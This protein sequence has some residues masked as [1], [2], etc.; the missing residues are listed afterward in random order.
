M[1]DAPGPSGPGGG[2]RPG[3]SWFHQHWKEVL[4]LMVA[5][6]PVAAYFLLRRQSNSNAAPTAFLGGGAAGGSSGGSGT[7]S[8]PASGPAT[9]WQNVTASI[10][11]FA[12]QGIVADWDRTVG[13][14]AGGIP[15]RP[16][17][18][19]TISAPLGYA[20]YGSSI[21]ITGPAIKAASNFGQ[22]A[23]GGSE[24]WYPIVT[25]SGLQGFI[26]AF[27]LASIP[28]AIAPPDSSNQSSPQVNLNTPAQVFSG[29]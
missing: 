24:W 11:G 13:A 19:D 3:G 27:D 4:A 9:T 6:I 14:K 21:T 18:G 10:R 22:G 7:P 8:P 16:G 2:R 17:A 26:S 15:I 23:S 12:T 1:A 28:N 5:V 29:L 25:E 20:E